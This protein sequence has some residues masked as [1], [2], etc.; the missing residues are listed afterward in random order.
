MAT[1]KTDLLIKAG[2]HY[3]WARLDRVDDISYSTPLYIC[4][5]LGGEHEGE[6]IAANRFHDQRGHKFTPPNHYSQF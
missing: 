5:V 2:S 1:Y 6:T 3:Q 4:T